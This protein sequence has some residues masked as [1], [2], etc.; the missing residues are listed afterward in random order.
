MRI[1]NAPSELD[2][3]PLIE[4]LSKTYEGISGVPRVRYRPIYKKHMFW[5]FLVD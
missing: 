5:F 2:L 4:H 3:E 1:P